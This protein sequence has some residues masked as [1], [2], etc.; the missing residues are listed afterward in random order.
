MWEEYKEIELSMLLRYCLL[1]GE[2]KEDP[3]KV[4]VEEEVHL[5][6]L[7][8]PLWTTL[9]NLPGFREEEEEEDPLKVQP[10]EDP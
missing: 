10:Q 9:G 8:V 7:K 5:V 3:L 4:L 6:T 2:D 1:E